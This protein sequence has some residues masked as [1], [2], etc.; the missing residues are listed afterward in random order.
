MKGVVLK[1]GD[2]AEWN[3][4]LGQLRLPSLLRDLV[5]G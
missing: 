4:V 2:I 1:T 5:K 3:L